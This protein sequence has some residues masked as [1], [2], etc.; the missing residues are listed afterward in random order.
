[1]SRNPYAVR[2]VGRSETDSRGTQIFCR[3]CGSDIKCSIRAN[4]PDAAH[5]DCPCCCPPI[6][7][8]FSS[9]AHGCRRQWITA[10]H[11]LT[12]VESGIPSGVVV[13][14]GGAR[15]GRAHPLRPRRASR[16]RRSPLS[17]PVSEEQVRR[18]R[19]CR[20]QYAARPESNTPATAHPMSTTSLRSRG[21]PL[22]F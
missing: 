2:L 9:T 12:D 22:R 13:G 21:R 20:P 14:A 1:M 15:P 11:D 3:A 17:P 4:R 19:A 5:R 10:L 18:A 16:S 7:F 6:R 8:F